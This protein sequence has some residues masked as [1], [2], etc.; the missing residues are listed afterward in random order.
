MVQMF[1]LEC[2]LNTTHSE[3]K[4]FNTIQ[5]S[6]MNNNYVCFHSLGNDYHSTKAYSEI[7]FTL[8]TEEGS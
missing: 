4:F 7:D 1:P 2:S 5:L 3:K 6:F 8:I